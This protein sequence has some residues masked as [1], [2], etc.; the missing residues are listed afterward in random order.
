M[1]KNNDKKWIGQKF[2]RLTII[3]FEK[4]K[5][6][7]RGWNWVCQCDCG[8]K[9][10]VSPQ[11]VKLG[12]TKSCG[13]YHDEVCKSR[14]TKYNHLVKDYPRLH[15]I[16]HWM[17]RRCYDPKTP[18]YED[19][20]GRG[21]S[22][23]R[24]WI[25]KAHGFD[26]FV[27]WAIENGYSDRLTLDRIDVNG[28]YCPENCRWVTYKEQNE[29]KRDTKWVVYKGKKIQL[30]RLCEKIGVCYDTVHNRIYSLGWDVERAIME[31]SQQENSLMK[32]CREKGMNYGT[33]RS[34]IKQFGWSEERAL[35]TPSIG[36][37]ANKKTYTK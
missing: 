16:Y 15:R 13:C 30:K 21:I 4:K 19:Y 34:R 9:K 25:D 35:N 29:N 8:N 5:E 2:G 31:P 33:V 10:V 7:N 22:V 6:P 27:Q 23:S 18:R 1:E 12:K 24:E 3:G 32:K 11:D 28:D 37:G 20:G 14:A 36:R 17:K 26:N